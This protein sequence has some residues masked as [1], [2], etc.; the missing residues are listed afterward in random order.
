[1][2]V[3][4]IWYKPFLFL[5]VVVV[6]VPAMLLFQLSL[7]RTLRETAIQKPEQLMFL[8]L[9]VMVQAQPSVHIL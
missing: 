5:A 3:A 4:M 2:L 6:L 8:I 9:V 7:R 1:M